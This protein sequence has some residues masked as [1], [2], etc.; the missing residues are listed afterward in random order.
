MT[1][2]LFVE[3]GCGS[4]SV[5]QSNRVIPVTTFQSNK[6]SISGRPT[7]FHDQKTN[8]KVRDVCVLDSVEY[9]EHSMKTWTGVGD[10]SI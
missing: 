5:L 4:E 6:C 7:I 1:T 3:L 8:N 9:L 10:L 2:L